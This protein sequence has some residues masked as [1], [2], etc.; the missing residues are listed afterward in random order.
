MPISSP[1][2]GHYPTPSPT[3]STY[4]LTPIPTPCCQNQVVVQL[5]TAILIPDYSRYYK[6]PILS[7]RPSYIP[8]GDGSLVTPVFVAD[9]EHSYALLFLFGFLAMLYT[10]NVF[11]A[12]S[13][14]RRTRA[15]YKLLFRMLF[16]SQLLA[17]AAIQPMMISYFTDSINC[18]FAVLFVL[19]A[20]VMS[21]TI[22][23]TGIYGVKVYKC[24][25]NSTFALVSVVL[26]SLG[27]LA[28]AGLDLAN[29]RGVRRLSGS[30]A[31]SADEFY[32]K[33]YLILQFA[34]SLFICFCF[35]YAVWKS[36]NSPVARGR[37]SIRLSMDD[38]S[39]RQDHQ[40]VNEIQPGHR[41]RSWRDCEAA[42][43]REPQAVSSSP[44]PD[45][46]PHPRPHSDKSRCAW[47]S[48]IRRWKS[49]DNHD[50]DSDSPE[51]KLSFDGESAESSIPSISRPHGLPQPSPPYPRPRPHELQFGISDSF[52][53]R[54]QTRNQP[55]GLLSPSSSS[56]SQ[57]SRYM[58][59]MELFRNVMKDEV[60]YTATIALCNVLGATLS[61]VGIN[62]TNSLPTI[63]WLSLSWLVVSVLTVHSF[64][65][66]IRRQEREYYI[67]QACSWQSGMVEHSRSRARTATASRHRTPY[68]RRVG[69]GVG[70]SSVD[71]G[72]DSQF[73]ETRAL[74][75]SHVSWDSRWSMSD[76]ISILNSPSR[77]ISNAISSGSPTQSDS[78]RPVT[79]STG[80]IVCIPSLTAQLPSS[81]RTT[82]VTQT[83]ISDS[84]LGGIV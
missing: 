46:D 18:T 57:L 61:I 27:V 23:M 42:T 34:Q 40:D 15:R 73:E 44:I 1:N 17:F 24:L 67:Q 49:D 16:V 2:H 76:S 54:S 48:F 8:L 66:V 79:G 72:R 83:F 39:V 6:G 26:F 62:F 30:C 31:R 55:C 71:H 63:G 29:T 51:R 10:L 14:L 60:C 59:R 64:G 13:Y 50:V 20:G 82:S 11:R 12:G 33:I 80:Q 84:E 41:A 7:F 45:P 52:K 28:V 47:F 77:S 69:I 56:F 74:T 65:R 3:L 19:G 21:L 25:D 22:L 58:P 4:T 36:R 5:Q 43:A 32:T 35:L 78:V 9:L 70:D 37:M 53:E 68:P 81:R 75:Q 38:L